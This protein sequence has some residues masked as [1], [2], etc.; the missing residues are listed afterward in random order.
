MRVWWRL[1]YAAGRS[2]A[3]SQVP[4]LV[5]D[6]AALLA[7][8]VSTEEAKAACRELNKCGKFLGGGCF[9]F[10]FRVWSRTAETCRSNLDNYT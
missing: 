8:K 1:A 6:L 3:G 9:F 4:R 7:C 2:H 5:V 10:F